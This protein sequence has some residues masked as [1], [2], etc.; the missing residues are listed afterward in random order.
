M[1]DLHKLVYDFAAGLRAADALGPQARS[2]RGSRV[3]QTG[4]GPHS[5][6]AAIK[7]TLDQMRARDEM[8]YRYVRPIPY[9][10]SRRRCD[11]GIGMPT[12][13][14]IEVKMARAFGDNGRLDDTYLKDLLSPYERDHS[15]LSD[16]T[17]LLEFDCRRAILIY[18]F[19]YPTRPLEQATKALELLMGAVVKISARV[20]ASFDGLVHPIHSSGRV[21]AW[22]VLSAVP[23]ETCSAQPL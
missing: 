3:Y 19:E 21:M 14:A 7:L 6:D 13:W 11:L 4:I 20:E 2:Q 16:A 12:T 15:A 10:H 23:P 1:L 9:P 22:E 8:T 18:G 5:E 17:K